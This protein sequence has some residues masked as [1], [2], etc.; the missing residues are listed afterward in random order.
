MI[1]VKK[2]IWHIPCNWL[3]ITTNGI[4]KADGQAV[5]GR[6]CALEAAQKFEEVPWELGKLIKRNGNKV[7]I[8]KKFT[9][10]EYVPIAEPGTFQMSQ[11][12]IS[13][14]A[15]PTKNDWKV[16]SDLKLIER[17]C[18]E[19]KQMYDNTIRAI[20]NSKELCERPYK[21]V[22]VIPRPGCGCGGLD[23]E[24]Q[25]KPLCEKYFITDDWIIA[26]K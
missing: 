12:V 3:C 17:S 1:E 15:F 22:I 4:L 16:P 26:T 10:D 8:I 18:Q 9:R 6:G 20:I 13:L 5:M 23:W 7:Q 11:V 19:L 2:D 14:I 25:I 24:T 21:P